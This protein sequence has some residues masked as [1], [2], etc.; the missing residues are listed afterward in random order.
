MKYSLVMP[1]DSVANYKFLA[2]SLWLYS[3]TPLIWWSDFHQSLPP[4]TQWSSWNF[5]SQS[6]DYVRAT[7]FAGDVL[8]SLGK[9]IEL[10]LCMY[11]RLLIYYTWMSGFF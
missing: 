6:F 9:L 2:R 8:L 4:R 10:L 3:D 5:T 7:L 1:V 11:L